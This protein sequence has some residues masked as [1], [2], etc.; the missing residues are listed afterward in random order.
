MACLLNDTCYVL[1]SLG[2]RR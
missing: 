2:C 1:R